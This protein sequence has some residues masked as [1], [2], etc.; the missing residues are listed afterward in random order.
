M[1][2]LFVRHYRW[3]E[4]DKNVGKFADL[5]KEAYRKIRCDELKA[6]GS[7]FIED[8]TFTEILD[9]Y[10]YYLNYRAIARDA[11]VSLIFFAFD[12]ARNTG[13]INSFDAGRICDL[14]H[15]PEKYSNLLFPMLTESGAIDANGRIY[16]W[17][18]FTFYLDADKERKREKRAGGCAMDADAPEPSAEAER[19]NTVPPRAEEARVTETEE[20]VIDRVNIINQKNSLENRLK[21]RTGAIPTE[22]VDSSVYQ[23]A[24]PLPIP[25]KIDEGLLRLCEKRIA[26]AA[27]Y[28]MRAV[29]SYFKEWLPPIVGD[30]SRMNPLLTQSHILDNIAVL[31]EISAQKYSAI[32]PDDLFAVIEDAVSALKQGAVVNIF[33]YLKRCI[34]RGNYAK[35]P[36]EWDGAD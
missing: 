31:F 7:R 10:D 35:D 34:H 6:A 11:F 4:A 12:H 18:E 8:S 15:F 32:K 5:L 29:S 23:R 21:H 26:K 36:M 20:E 14:I 19:E 13:I 3:I 2:H 33:R 30:I 24:E 17:D 9:R 25:V 22:S 28:D 16:R 1:K 27:E